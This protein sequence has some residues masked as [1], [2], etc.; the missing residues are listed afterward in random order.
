MMY[1]GGIILAVLLI[2]LVYNWV[3]YQKRKKNRPLVGRIKSLERWDNY[4]YKAQ[5]VLSNG[6]NGEYL[7]FSKYFLKEGNDVVLEKKGKNFYKVVKVLEVPL[8]L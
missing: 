5:M 6:K 7:L 2:A 1:F 8:A 3:N 4:L